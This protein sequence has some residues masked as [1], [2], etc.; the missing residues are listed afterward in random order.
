MLYPN[1]DLQLDL[2]LR[3]YLGD[4]GGGVANS[5]ADFGGFPIEPP[6][7]VLRRWI[8]AS[9]SFVVV[10]L[11]RRRATSVCISFTSDVS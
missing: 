1:G 7:L 2:H 8:N 4:G 3:T 10:G 9:E 5:N 11:A 6:I